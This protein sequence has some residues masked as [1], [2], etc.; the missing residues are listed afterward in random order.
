MGY[1]AG[2]LNSV[3]SPLLTGG[4]IVILKK[5]GAWEMFNLLNLIIEKKINTIWLVPSII[6]Y[7]NNLKLSLKIKK[8]IK[9]TLKNIFVGTAPYH[10]S[11]KKLFKKN[12]ELH[13]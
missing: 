12:L 4:T 1:M 11:L 2:F 9:D 5:F 8:Q 13:H 10:D 7:L 3:L 6:N